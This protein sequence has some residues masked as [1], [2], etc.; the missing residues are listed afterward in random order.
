[1]NFVVEFYRSRDEDGA[2]AM[3]DRIVL[4]APNLR[5]ALAAAGAMLQTLPLPQIPDGLRICDE[6]GSQL[7]AGPTSATP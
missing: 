2:H 1:V 6:D 7:Y 3:L 5:A 4:D